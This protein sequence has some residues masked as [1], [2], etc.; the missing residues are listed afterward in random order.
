MEYCRSFGVSGM[1]FPNWIQLDT[2]FWSFRGVF[3][4]ETTFFQSYPAS[5]LRGA[6]VA[7]VVAKSHLVRTWGPD[8]L[9]KKT[10][11]VWTWWHFNFFW[12]KARSEWPSQAR[13]LPS[14][15]WWR[16]GGR[17]GKDTWK[18]SN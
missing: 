16:L 10:L 11:R 4:N 13:S 15:Y 12:R 5:L 14:L 7:A 1:P 2:H 3:S 6:V 18:F 9:V 17:F 8:F